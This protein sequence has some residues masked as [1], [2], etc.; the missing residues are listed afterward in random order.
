MNLTGN[1]ITLVLYDITNHKLR[2][3]IDKAMK[4]FGIRLQFSVFLCRLDADGIARCYDKLRK[5]IIENRSYKSDSD[6]V[7]IV[8]R[9]NCDSVSCILGNEGVL[10]QSGF[11]IY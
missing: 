11:K 10:N 8:Q 2:R 9:I 5:V 3:R 1:S 6:S 7:I 4:D